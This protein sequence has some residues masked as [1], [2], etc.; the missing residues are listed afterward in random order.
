MKTKL[1]ILLLV[2][3]WIASPGV[4]ACTTFLMKDAKNNLYYG[5]NFDFPVGEGLIQINERNMVKQAM[6]LPSDKPFSWVS[7]YGSITFNQ[8]GREFPYGGM[9]EAGLV[10]E[11]MWLDG[12]RYPGKQRSHRVPRRHDG[13][14]SRQRATGS[15]TDELNL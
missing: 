15:R 11:Q 6:V 4:Q 12:T 3:G 5:R 13:G 7:L 1:F 14:A 10:V 9:N 8:V 2:S